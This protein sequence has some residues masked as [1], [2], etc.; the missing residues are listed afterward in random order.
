MQTF[1]ATSGSRI[2]A[3]L[4]MRAAA[5]MPRGADEVQ[6]AAR[7]RFARG[8]EVFAEGDAGTFFYKVVSGTVRTGKLLADGR[9]QIDAFHLAGDVFGLES[10]DRHRFTAEAVDDVVV[11]AYRRSRFASLVHDDPE[12]GELLMASM[13]TSLDRAH[14]HM[15]LLGRKTALEKIASFLLDMASRRPG[16]D[17]VVLPMQRTDIADHLGLTIETVSRTLT[18]MVRDGLIRL[19]EAGRTVILADRAAL[20]LLDA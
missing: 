1:T 13:L 16:A 15:V 3:A 19:A 2:P 8:E 7:Q 6:H 5:A 11:I 4:A 14:D 20:Q 9:R 12:F 18:Q 17:K 10:G